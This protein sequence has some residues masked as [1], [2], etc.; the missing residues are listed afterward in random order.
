MPLSSPSSTISLICVGVRNQQELIPIVL[1]P[2]STLEWSLIHLQLRSRYIGISSSL[3]LT[4][5][6]SSLVMDRQGIPSSVYD[7][8]DGVNNYIYKASIF[9]LQ[10]QMQGHNQD[11]ESASR[12]SPSTFFTPKHRKG[13]T[14]TTSFPHK[15]RSKMQGWRRFRPCWSTVLPLHHLQGGDV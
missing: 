9:D 11:C 15:K 14:S 3:Y 5:I 1:F 12:T 8:N 10:R 13:T 2:C 6:C 4:H 7:N